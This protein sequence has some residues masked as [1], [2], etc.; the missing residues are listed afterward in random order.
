MARDVRE[1]VA[2][3]SRERVPRVSDDLA[4]A[5]TCPVCGASPGQRCRVAETSPPSA[6]I[7]RPPHLRRKALGAAWLR[8]RVNA[9]RTQL[10][11]AVAEGLG[12]ASRIT[13]PVIAQPELGLREILWAWIVDRQHEGNMFG[14]ADAVRILMPMSELVE[15]LAC[16]IERSG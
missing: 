5:V 7:E 10:E 2:R 13:R 8:A 6:L 9:E 3:G 16:A 11:R 12:M 4:D 15:S 1:I 14:D